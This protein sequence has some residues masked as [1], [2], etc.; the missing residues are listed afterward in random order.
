MHYSYGSDADSNIY[1][2]HEYVHN[3]NKAK[4]RKAA[5][6]HNKQPEHYTHVLTGCVF[7]MLNKRE[8][9]AISGQWL[10]ATGRW[11]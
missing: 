6:V 2:P 8:K 4:K 10:S 5:L 11:R 9:E 7:M 3:K 1:F